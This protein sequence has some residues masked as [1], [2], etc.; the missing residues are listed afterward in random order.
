MNFINKINKYLL[1]HYPLIWNTRLVWMIGVNI[2]VHLLFFIIGFSS[3]N[4]LEDLKEQF[5]LES[6]FFNTSNVYYNFLYSILIILI[7]I[8][9]Y[10]RNNAFKNLYNLPKLFLFKQFC[11]ILFIFFIS[12][13][14]Y[15]SFKKGLTIKIKSLYD[16]E[17]V[18]N[19]IKTFNKIALFLVQSQD[20]YE[21]NKKQYPEPFP[22]KVAVSYNN[23]T[24][25]NIDTTKV[26]I[27][28][29][30]TL[31]QFYK[32]K[33]EEVVNRVKENIYQP[34]FSNHN[35]SDRIVED[36]GELKKFFQPSLKNYSKEIFT[37]GQSYTDFKNQ[38]KYQQEILDSQD[39]FKIQEDLKT[40]LALADKYNADYNIDA[41][42]WFKIINNKPDYFLTKLIGES[43]PRNAD[44]NA[45][46][47]NYDK[48]DFE[49]SDNDS[50]ISHSKTLYFSFNRTDNFFKNVYLSYF[51]TFE[52]EIFYFLLIFAIVLSILLFIFKTTSLKTILLSVVA[53]LV[54][55]VL[56]VWMMSSSK[57]FYSTGAK[58]EYFVMIFV[59]FT[60][61]FGAVISYILKWKK[62]IISIFWSLALF[63][64][65]TLAFFLAVDYIKS[66]SDNHRIDFPNDYGF[67]SNFEIWFDVYGFWTIIFIW[68][69]TIFI[70]S[71]FIRKLR[72]RVE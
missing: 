33:D 58:K 55:L 17:E 50:Y 19:D 54:V 63:A 16:W 42:N 12:I 39:D 3:V 52:I 24:R 70:Y 43:D 20:D 14:Q 8:V 9:Y 22:L 72:A 2:L 44:L 15:F 47:Y 40:F 65:P 28:R 26:H 56:I 49:Y 11:V 21:I 37:Y 5:N 10:L 51:P 46:K 36:I 6:F 53:S 27:N 57:I 67:K 48:T 64:T 59:S 60:I 30:G 18:D 41:E 34:K 71:L 1:E 31:Y 62:I 4:G 13:S 61:V 23:D 7:W 29:K 35:F 68:V 45:L 38:I 25:D 32:L 66:L 69:L